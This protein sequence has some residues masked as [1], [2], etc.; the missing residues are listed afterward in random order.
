MLSCLLLSLGVLSCTSDDDSSPIDKLAARAADSTAERDVPYVPTSEDVVT[1]MLELAEV[2][3][4]DTVYD[5]GSGD[6]RIVITAAQRY[7]ARAVGIEIDPVRV[8]EAR[9]N[10]TAAG[11]EDRV[12]FKLGDLFEADFS[13][14]TVVTLYLLP[15]VN[16]KLRPLL[17]D[18]LKPGTRVVS[19]N[20]DMGA[21]TP[22]TTE[23]VGPS[24]IYR[25]TIPET[26]PDSLTP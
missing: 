3:P 5:L 7:R 16:L 25:W 10:A 2:G 18:Q 23:T 9:Q 11:V 6:G 20:F 13:D 22:D 26:P 17:F 19:H 8:W 24:V 1:R 4:G 21:W 14:A 15:E 12:T